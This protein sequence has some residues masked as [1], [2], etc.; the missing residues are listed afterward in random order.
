MRA[1]RALL[2]LLLLAGLAAGIIWQTPIL[3]A[4]SG[5]PPVQRVRGYEADGIRD[6]VFALPGDDRLVRLVTNALVPAASGGEDAGYSISVEIERPNIPLEAR[7]LYLKTHRSGPRNGTEDTCFDNDRNPI[8]DSRHVDLEL[9]PPAPPGTL[10]RVKKLGNTPTIVRAWS[11]QPRAGVERARRLLALDPGQR[12]RLGEPIGLR[13]WDH[14]TEAEKERWTSGHFSRLA[15]TGRPDL[16]HHPHD[17][18]VRDVERPETDEESVPTLVSSPLTWLTNGP[19]QAT[20]TVRSTPIT[21]PATLELRRVSDQETLLGS[22]QIGPGSSPILWSGDL[23]TGPQTLVL[24]SSTPTLVNLEMLIPGVSQIPQLPSSELLRTDPSTV[25]LR[26]APVRPGQDA[27]LDA[28]LPRNTEMRTVEIEVWGTEAVDP[29]LTLTAVGP[30]H[31]TVDRIRPVLADNNYDVAVDALG[32]EHSLRGPARLKLLVPADAHTVSVAVD[33]GALIRFRLPFHTSE[34]DP[35]PP[36]TL[37]PVGVPDGPASRSWVRAKSPQEEVEIRL[38]ARIEPVPPPPIPPPSWMAISLDPLGLVQR[39]E[40]LERLTGELTGRVLTEVNGRVRVQAGT[41]KTRAHWSF[42]VQDSSLLGSS[43]PFL[44]DGQAGGTIRAA[45]SR[46]TVRFPPL[47]PGVHTVEAQPPAGMRLF[48]NLPPALGASAPTYRARTVYRVSQPIQL[49]VRTDARGPRALNVVVY[50]RSASPR[51][52]VQVTA[53]VDGG[54]PRRRDHGVYTRATPNRRTWPLPVPTHPD[55][56]FLVDGDRENIGLPRT[57]I[58]PLGDDLVPGLH[59]ILIQ[60]DRGLYMRFFAV[61]PPDL[62]D[63]SP[64]WEPED[65]GE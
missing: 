18:Y 13:S 44:L 9:D 22:W 58:L 30:N 57:L 34:E 46:G 6:P 36:S 56:A 52:D 49:T 16:E 4:G 28:E 48:V 40:A 33:A 50:D 10:I 32:A 63:N 65:N 61:T 60:P 47:E 54:S 25:T 8:A 20:L 27:V 35:G 62:S 23:P 11:W 53:T 12:R 64:H 19:A 7:L 42:E 45:L 43:V 38:K 51:D 41:G 5:A 39:F 2:L 29:S 55:A 1:L 15:A 14:M 26:A 21:V 37:R 59:T 17:F 31:R 3:F 24:R